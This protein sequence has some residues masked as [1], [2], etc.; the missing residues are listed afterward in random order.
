MT[1]DET[2]NKTIAAAS[3]LREFVSPASV[4][5]DCCVV[6]V[7]PPGF[8]LFGRFASGRVGSLDARRDDPLGA[9]RVGSLDARPDDSSREAS[10]ARVVR[11]GLDDFGLDF[12]DAGFFFLAINQKTS[13][14]R[15]PSGV[16]LKAI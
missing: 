5:L 8:A 13:V 14:G 11:G 2:T 7:A 9:C 3:T 6:F 1:T 15:F 10:L 12:L 16:A 4:V